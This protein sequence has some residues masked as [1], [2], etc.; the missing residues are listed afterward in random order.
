MDDPSANYTQIEEILANDMP[1]IP[2]YHYS[3]NMMLND[4][5]RNWPIN[6]VEQNWYSRNLYRVD[7]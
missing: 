4:E 5:I 7:N 1:V 6:N 2:V 3:G